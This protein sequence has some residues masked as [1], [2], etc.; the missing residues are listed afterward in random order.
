MCENRDW[1]DTY[2]E[3][4]EVE[5]LMGNDDTCKVIGTVK[6]K[7]H[8]NIIRTFGNVQHVPYLK[9]NLI[10]LGTLDANGNTYSSSGGK[11][12]ICKGSMVIMRGEMLLNNFYKLFGD[13]ISGGAAISTPE[14]SKDD[15]AHP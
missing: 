15:L 9:K 5:V 14:N 3:K 11:L 13:T 10:F 6:V 7:M 2:K 1:F 12:K 8:D 4:N